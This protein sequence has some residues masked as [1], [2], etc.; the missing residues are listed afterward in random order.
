[1]TAPTGLTDTDEATVNI[2]AI[3]DDFAFDGFRA[4]RTSPTSTRPISGRS[5][6]GSRRRVL[7]ALVRK[8]ETIRL[9]LGS[10]SE[11]IEKRLRTGD[12][13]EAANLTSNIGEVFLDRGQTAEAEAS[14]R[15]V[16]RIA[17]SAG[18]TH[19]LAF[20]FGSAPASAQKAR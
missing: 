4:S 5:S 18:Y 7:R 20:R 13:V 2:A 10:L 14:F 17:R 6:Y 8:T 19:N 16:L 1:V 11:V 15:E 3:D 9:E 12:A